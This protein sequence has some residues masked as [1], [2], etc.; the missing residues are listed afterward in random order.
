M[1]VLD[2]SPEVAESCL[3]MAIALTQ[4][5]QGQ[6]QLLRTA[7]CVHRTYVRA[8]T[9]P[10][11]GRTHDLR[12]RR[13]VSALDAYLERCPPSAQARKLRGIVSE[14]ADLLEQQAALAS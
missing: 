5:A 3:E 7:S 11:Q 1:N 13:F 8:V 2:L 6:A 12:W 4:T 14:N 10:L 9:P